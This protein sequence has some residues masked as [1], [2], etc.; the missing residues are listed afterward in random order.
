MQLGSRNEQKLYGP[1]I[2]K[3]KSISSNK[4]AKVR[5]ISLRHVDTTVSYIAE[6]SCFN[7]LIACWYGEK[8]P[9]RSFKHDGSILWSVNVPTRTHEPGRANGGGLVDKWRI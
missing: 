6:I 3:V 9:H 2:Q 1:K 8:L 4:I 7:A 5:N